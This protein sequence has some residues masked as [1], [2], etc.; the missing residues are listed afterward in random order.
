MPDPHQYVV[1]RIAH[2]IDRYITAF[3][4]FDALSVFGG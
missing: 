4:L 1:E 3:N 2:S